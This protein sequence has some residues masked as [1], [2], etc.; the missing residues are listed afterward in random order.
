VSA[1]P[2]EV[3]RALVLAAGRGSRLD[4]ETPKPLFPVLGIPLLARTLFTLEKAGI[5]DAW[6]VVGYRGEEVRR[7]IESIERLG[8]R[9]HWIHNE[10]WDEPNGVSVL[11]AEP[12]LD[13]PFVL[14]M[15]DHVF[16]AAAVE[17]L[18]KG[19]GGLEGVDLVVDREIEAVNDLDDA[20]KVRLEGDRIVEI[21]KSLDDFDVVDTGVF[22]ASPELFEAL[23]EAGEAPSL[24][25][26]VR[27]L[28]GK[29]RAR[30][31]DGS[32]ITWQDVDTPDDVDAA[33]RKLL[34]QWPKETDG[35]VS[36]RINR[37]LST[38]I[39]RRIA[40]TGITPNQVSVA[41][42]LVSLVGA[43]LAAV[44]G[45]FAWLGTGVL[46]QL[47]SILDGVDGEVA[48]LTHRA[49]R[50]GE[51]V[52]TVCDN[53]SYV[54]FLVGLSVGVWRAEMHPVYLWGGVVGVVAATLSIANIKLYL[55]RTKDSGSAR[56]VKY[57][58]E[59]GDGVFSRLLQAAHYLGKRDVFSFLFLVLAVVGQLPLALPMVGAGA[60]LLLLPATTKANL[61]SFL[62][63]RRGAMST[64]TGSS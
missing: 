40:G 10:R 7:G 61:S 49:S 31:V 17:R 47:A 52:D 55:L 41:T 23:R 27:A 46:V 48:I 13:G 9:V 56:A 30:A 33:E 59:G 54:A 42:L 22:L 32:G 36:R 3:R 8:L 2:S 57:G 45:Y 26:G 1:R 29:G 50:R 43:G 5:T 11:A 35:P 58:Y 20:T 64:E 63:A 51:W 25:D 6:V 34:A 39:T 19:A 21:G 16:D 62:R 44:G 14:T 53:V 24:S 15:A 60:G 4:H 28:A 37:P 18:R 12:E 38:R